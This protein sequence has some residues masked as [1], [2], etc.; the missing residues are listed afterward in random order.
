MSEPAPFKPTS[1]SITE[2]IDPNNKNPHQKVFAASYPDDWPGQVMNPARVPQ[3]YIVTTADVSAMELEDLYIGHDDPNYPEG[4]DA[5]LVARQRSLNSSG[6][7]LAVLQFHRGPL[8]DGVNGLFL[9]SLFAIAANQTGLYQ[10]SPFACPENERIRRH[11]QGA[12]R[13]MGERQLRRTKAGT[14]GT[15]KVDGQTK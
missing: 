6:L 9:E 7:V 2:V 12:L 5:D 14:F 15:H 11:A 1:L 8:A 13:K 4:Y 10:Q 3:F